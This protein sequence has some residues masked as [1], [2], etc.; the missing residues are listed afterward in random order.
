MINEVTYEV[1]LSDAERFFEYAGQH[2]R[3]MRS[4]LLRSRWV[5]LDHIELAFDTQGS[6]IGSLWPDLS[7]SYKPQKEK[8]WGFIYPI[9]VASGRMKR[10]AT[11][12]RSARVRGNELI[13]HVNVPYAG[14]HQYGGWTDEKGRQHPPQRSFFAKTPELVGEI[15]MV[16]YEWLEEVKARNVRRRTRPGINPFEP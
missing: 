11:S 4:P 10:V 6:S 14:A 8:K 13:Y 3:S 16:F 15:E 9:L 7:R 5:L 12:E 2:A 1:D